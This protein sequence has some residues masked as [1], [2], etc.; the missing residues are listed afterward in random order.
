LNW[1][2]GGSSGI[3][4]YTAIEFAKQGAYIAVAGRRMDAL[5]ETSRLCT[6]EGKTEEHNVNMRALRRRLPPLQFSM[7]AFHF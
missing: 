1:F 5:Q 3:G 6:L 7:H 2:L 4:R